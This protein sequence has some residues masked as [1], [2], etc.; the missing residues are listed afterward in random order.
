MTASPGGLL[1]G[2]I[3]QDSGRCKPPT[4]LR[5]EL[6]KQAYTRQSACAV[7]LASLGVE[8]RPGGK[9]KPPA[10]LARP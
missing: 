9:A 7:G 4:R 1:G 5:S 3:D 8:L 10:V 2:M 6:V